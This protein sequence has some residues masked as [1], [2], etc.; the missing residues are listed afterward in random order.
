MDAQNCNVN[1]IILAVNREIESDAR[2]IKRKKEF[3]EIPFFVLIFI[4]FS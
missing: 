3:L 4:Y 1:Q 2:Q